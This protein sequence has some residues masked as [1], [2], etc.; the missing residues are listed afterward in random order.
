MDVN[1]LQ[2]QD[3]SRAAERHHPGAPHYYLM[4]VGTLPQYKGRG[5]GSRLIGHVLERCDREGMPAYLENSSGDNL[6]FYTA[7]GFWVIERIRF[8]ASVP[9]V[10]MMWR[11]APAASG[12]PAAQDEL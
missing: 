4:T 8:A 10:W 12:K 11:E 3:V 7:H 5:L 6:G 1:T 2:A 9:P